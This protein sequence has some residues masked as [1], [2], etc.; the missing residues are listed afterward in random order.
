MTEEVRNLKVASSDCEALALCLALGTLEAIRSGAWPV[1]ATTWT[2]ARPAFRIPLI[3][4]G[5]PDEVLAVFSG[6]DE[7]SALATLAG[8]DAVEER[9]A[10]MMAVIRKRLAMLSEPSW[11]ARWS[12]E[13]EAVIGAHIPDDWT[14]RLS[15]AIAA[16]KREFARRLADRQSPCSR[17]TATHGMVRSGFR[18]SPL[19]RSMR[20]ACWQTRLRWLRGGTTISPAVRR[21]G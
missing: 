12:E 21:R 19:P 18:H 11:Y 20:M 16:A 6:A 1:E 10:D 7:L 4:A 2:I 5:I 13:K 8:R 3:A 9:I 15:H 14:L 17:W